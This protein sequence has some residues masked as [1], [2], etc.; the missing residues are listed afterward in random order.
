MKE[1]TIQYIIKIWDNKELYHEMHEGFMVSVGG[2]FLNT[3]QTRA[4]IIADVPVMLKPIEEAI[5][6]EITEKIALLLL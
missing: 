1:I 3:T 2:D 4:N 5:S 6:E